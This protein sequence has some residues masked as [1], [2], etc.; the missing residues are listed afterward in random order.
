MSRC[1]ERIRKTKAQMEL[2]LVRDMKNNKK[3]FYGYIG[4]MRQAKESVPSLIKGSGELTSS[5]IEKA[6]VLSECFASVF[7]GDQ[8]SHVIK[9]PEPLGEGVGNG[10]HPTVTVEQV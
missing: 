10:F 7:T 5:E 1:V 8:A 2:N 9:D 4:K 6:E 3:G